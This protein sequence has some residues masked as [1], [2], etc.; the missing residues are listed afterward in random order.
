MKPM[1]APSWPGAVRFLAERLPA[2]RA[3]HFVFG[4]SCCREAVARGSGLARVAQGSA[5][6]VPFP[7]AA[8][9]I[10]TSFDVLYCLPDAIERE[11]VREMKR[12]IREGAAP[13][14]RPD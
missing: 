8:F 6:A 12:L 9:D 13:G 3:L 2:D 1:L 7:S 10:V 11:A 14:L 4:A 5:A